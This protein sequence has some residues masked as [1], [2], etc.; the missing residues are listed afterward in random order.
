MKKIIL[1][2][3]GMVFLT[4]CGNNGINNNVAVA[5]EN[6]ESF[7]ENPYFKSES[8]LEESEGYKKRTLQNVEKN[9]YNTFLEAVKTIFHY[10]Y[11]IE[12]LLKINGNKIE[13]IEKMTKSKFY[14]N[15]GDGLNYIYFTPIKEDISKGTIIK[16]DI[17]NYTMLEYHIT[18]KP[19]LSILH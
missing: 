7:T 5:P 13:K 9:E 14:V 11:A 16:V 8:F 15:K 19:L 4:N 3:L 6:R 1:L 17:P 10:N 18:E 2:V 12:E